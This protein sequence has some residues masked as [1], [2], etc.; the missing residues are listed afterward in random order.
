MIKRK[1]G[2]HMSFKY[3]KKLPSTEDILRMVPLEQ[4]Y[5]DIKQIRDAEIK[6]VFTG[7][8][9]KFIL[10]IGPCSTDNEDAV[11]EYIYRLAGVQE[12]VKDKIIIIPRIY[13]NKPRTTGEGYKGMMHQPNPNEAPDMLEGILAI[14]RVHVRA[15]KETH[16]FAADEMLYPMNYPMVEDLLSYIA[17]GAR[18]VENQKHRLTASGMDFPV[19]MKN[20]TSGDISVMLNSIKAAQIEH[21]YLYNNY[22]VE[23]SG[24]PLAHAILRGAVN[25]YGRN[26]PNYHYEDIMHLV[27]SYV[28][29]NLDNPSII[30]DCNHANSMK[31]YDQQPRIAMEILKNRKYSDTMQGM[32]KGMM[33]E[34]YLEDGSQ[35]TTGSVFGKSITDPCLGWE[36]SER[37]IY[38]IADK[39]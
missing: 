32:L 10:I 30:I 4:K 19:G 18:S 17:V 23:T 15:I 12:K 35:D 27:E 34:S 25:Q 16:L 9:D 28:E 36:K 7:K 5:K 6:D 3:V 20:P 24:N 31:K 14:R 1:G 13:T 29:R 22:E 8:S 38:D 37:L 11:C 39:L 2:I 33:I 21:T 26:I